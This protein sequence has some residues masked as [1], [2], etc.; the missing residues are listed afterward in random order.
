MTYEEA[1]QIW[2]RTG[3]YPLVEGENLAA[4]VQQA[5][6][7]LGRGDRDELIAYLLEKPLADIRKVA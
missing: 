2:E 5:R 3:E 4:R 6:W 1:Y 7:L